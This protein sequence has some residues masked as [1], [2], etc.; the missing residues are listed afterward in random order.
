MSKRI[1]FNKISLE[2]SDLFKEVPEDQMREKVSPDGRC[3][4]ALDHLRDAMISITCNDAIDMQDTKK[5]AMETG[6][7]LG[8]QLENYRKDGIYEKNI[9]NLPV[10]VLRYSY[11]S[12]QKHKFGLMAFFDANQDVFVL[13]FVTDNCFGIEMQQEFIN[14]LDTLLVL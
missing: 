7:L 13:N 14:I 10:Y 2:I 5:E 3:W 9:N 1:I 6:I 4:I 12:K 8:N 11:N